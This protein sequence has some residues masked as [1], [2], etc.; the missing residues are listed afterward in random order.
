MLIVGIVGCKPKEA[1]GLV[2]DNW[3]E[4]LGYPKGSRV[5][6]LH[7]DDIGMCSEANEAVKP[8]L[9]NGQIQSAAAMVPCPWFNDFAEWSIKN[10]T[11]DI[12]LHLTLTSEWQ[13][14]RW[15]SISNPSDVPGLIDNDG[16][17]WH[18]V[19]DVVMHASAAEVEKEIR[20][21]IDRAIDVGMKPDH[22]DTHMGT[23][24]GH[25][26]YAK[27]FFNVAMEYNIPANVID[28]T[29]ANVDKF[30]GQGY[31]ISDEMISYSEN[32]TLPKLDDFFSVPNGN[33]YEEKKSNF[34]Q[35]IRSLKPGI[36]EIIFH[37]SIESEGLKKITNSWQQRVWEAK[38]FSDLDVIQFMKNEGLIFT[39][40]KEMMSRFEE[41][42]Q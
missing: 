6:I 25:P 29:L 10:E 28:F 2:G 1:K 9:K 21:Q 30:K 26:D 19:P 41:R 15:E 36:S 23:L 3:A 8:Y 14:Y 42:S 16:Y 24:Y 32:Y 33:T 12:G 22:I 38:M 39:N 18:E 7:A 4:K 40:W 37:P 20:A 13:T 35:L 31:P 11:L 34:F 5:V 27:A 17:F